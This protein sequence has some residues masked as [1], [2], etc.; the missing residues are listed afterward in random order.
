MLACLLAPQVAASQKIIRPLCTVY[1][2]F[3]KII[4][5]KK[6]VNESFN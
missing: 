4:C 5:N 3:V 2:N 6:H 1:C